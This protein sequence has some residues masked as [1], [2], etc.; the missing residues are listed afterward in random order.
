RP[1]RK[2]IF[3]QLKKHFDFVYMPITQPDHEQFP[4][5]WTL[6]E[7]NLPYARAIFIASRQKQE[8]P[9]LE[10]KIPEHQEYPA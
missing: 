1:G 6:P 4:T 7:Y 3:A 8:N 2:W 9:L 5:D 10:E